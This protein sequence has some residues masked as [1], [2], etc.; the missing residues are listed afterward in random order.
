MIKSPDLRSIDLKKCPSR[1][2]ALYFVFTKAKTAHNAY[3]IHIATEDKQ[4]GQLN[5]WLSQVTHEP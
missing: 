2:G 3:V 5:T 1:C 4:Q